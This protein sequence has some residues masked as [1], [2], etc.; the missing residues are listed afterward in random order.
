MSDTELRHQE[1]DVT[2]QTP[3][4][5]RFRLFGPLEVVSDHVEVDLGPRKQRAV[6]TVLLLQANVV[7]STDRIIDRVW[8]ESP[9]RTA[10]HS[11]QVYISDLRKTISDGS[12]ED[13]I[14]TRAPG[15]V[16]NTPPDAIDI[17][18]FERSIREGLAAVRTGDLTGGLP[19]LDR[20]IAAWTGEPLA[21]FEYE[22]FAQGH[23]RTLSELRTDALEALAGVAL[24]QGDA[25][26]VRQLAQDA[27]ASDPLREE[28]RRLMMLALYGSGRQAEALRHFGDY[29]RLLA[30]EL[31]IE[32]SKG[33]RELEE[34]VLLQDPTLN[35]AVSPVAE[36]N[37]YR[38]LRPFSEDDVDVY[39]GRE[40]LVAEALETLKKPDGFVSIVGPSGSGKSSAARAGMIPVLRSAGE[41][42]VVLQPGAQPLWELAGALDRAGLDS[43]ADLLHRFE[44]DSDA[45][46]SVVD[47]PLVLVIDQFEELF[48]LAEADT[49]AR[50]AELI[51]SGVRDS[52]TPFRVVATLRADYYDRP[53]SLPA[54]AGAFSESV[55]SVKPMTPLEIER[56]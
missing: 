7:V 53:L 43:R 5:F 41:T 49:A 3:S 28:P 39:F 33:L 45:M 46:V 14:E 55:V 20:A 4:S 36:D 52:E 47:R 15:Y 23:I 40:S 42:V 6:L 32:P 24:D 50:F 48:T 10:E 29:Q 54:L 44:T 26:R 12:G 30:E 13:L 31:G 11:I 38:G 18:R 21:D 37:P 22:A 16:L 34:R 17:H 56:D 51:S 9:P 25:D 19:K 8:G 2:Y 27:I 35:L 1:L